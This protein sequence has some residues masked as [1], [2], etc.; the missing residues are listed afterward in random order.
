LLSCFFSQ[1][2]TSFACSIKQKTHDL[3][4]GFSFAE[5]EGFEPPEV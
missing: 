1:A 5:K 2:K 3:R 4:H